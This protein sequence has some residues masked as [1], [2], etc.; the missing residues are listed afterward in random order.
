MSITTTFLYKKCKNYRYYVCQMRNS[1]F[2]CL[3]FKSKENYDNWLKQNEV[4]GSNKYKYCNHFGEL[5]NFFI[6]ANSL[7]IPIVEDN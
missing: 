3:R 7:N 5:D 6:F 2:K 4:S 1:K